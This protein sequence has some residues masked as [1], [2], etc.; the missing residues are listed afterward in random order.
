ML[1]R[2]P[3]LLA[4]LLLAGLLGSASA[5][6]S[7]GGKDGFFSDRGM[8]PQGGM[9]SV[10]QAR[11]R[12]ARA[13]QNIIQVKSMPVFQAG[14]DMTSQFANLDAMLAK[15]NENLASGNAQ[16]VFDICAQIDQ[17]IGE[18]FSK[19]KQQGDN[20]NTAQMDLDRDAERFA[21]LAQ[22]FGSG[23][24]A[25][26]AEM[27]GKIKTLL[28]DARAQIGG[29]RP[30]LSR[31]YLTQA[32]ALTAEL[33]RLA[34]ESSS[35]EKGPSS[36]MTH[37]SCD[38]QQPSTQAAAVQ[39]SE[40]YRRIL[41][42]FTRLTEQ[43]AESQDPK[44][45]AL[46]ARIQE[47]LDKAKEAIATGQ[48]EAAR[49]FCLKSESLLP[50][51]SKTVSAQGGDRLSPAAWQRLKAKMD[52]A[53]EI[54]AGSGNDKASRIL[55]K[56]QEHFERAERNHADGQ[57]ARAEVEMDIALKL[58]AKAVDIARSNGR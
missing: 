22:R 57:S 43:A 40:L 7:E 11:D 36:S 8:P 13:T 5:R 20:K 2:H 14:Q 50:D 1:A 19:G 25:C 31:P 3:K 35:S 26:A 44:A 9:L 34:Q 47:F 48:P 17:R 23:K 38:D 45:S 56:G 15:A 29:A 41:E 53:A 54:V 4:L 12:L 6:S 51:L 16:A 33:Q 30:E 24:N 58:A 55:E 27:M 32:E 28:D 49:E 52:R 37:G 46:K 21:S 18:I 10:D 42:R 39:A